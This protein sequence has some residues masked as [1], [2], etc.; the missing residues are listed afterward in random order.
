MSEVVGTVPCRPIEK[1]E[2]K[3]SVSQT[4]GLCS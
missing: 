1:P 4:N 3:V 2:I